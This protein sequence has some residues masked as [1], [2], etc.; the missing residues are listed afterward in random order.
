MTTRGG[1]ASVGMTTR[2]GFASV[3]MTTETRGIR[4]VM[5]KKAMKE[6]VE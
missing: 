2:G 1:F 5:V 4:G 6:R 3:G